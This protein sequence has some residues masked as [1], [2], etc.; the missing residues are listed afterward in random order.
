M[1]NSIIYYHHPDGSGSGNFDP[2]SNDVHITRKT[3][4]YDEGIIN[5]V[6][7]TGLNYTNDTAGSPVHTEW[8]R[9]EILHYDISNTIATLP[10]F[11]TFSQ[12]VMDI[13]YSAP[14]W[15][16][17][18]WEFL[19]VD[20]IPMDFIGYDLSNNFAS[21]N[22]VLH[23]THP[24]DTSNNTNIYYNIKIVYWEPSEIDWNVDYI[25]EGYPDV[26][27]T[28]DNNGGFAYIREGPFII[29]SP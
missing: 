14:Q 5:S 16:D 20:N 2:I 18:E 12:A 19:M 17:L 28:Q 11:Q 8:A 24:N 1:N 9:G 7:E 22:L 15:T 6:Y 10:Q 26:G 23:L 4:C 27:H 3:N 21:T 25:A 13:T 29:T